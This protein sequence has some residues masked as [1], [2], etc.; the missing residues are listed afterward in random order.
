MVANELRFVVGSVVAAVAV[1]RLVEL[2]VLR[3]GSR[4]N[5]RFDRFVLVVVA[6]RI[7]DFLR[8]RQMRQLGDVDRRTMLVELRIREDVVVRIHRSWK[9]LEVHIR[10]P[11]Q[12]DRHDRTWV[13][14]S[15]IG[16]LE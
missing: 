15:C 12:R 11:K 10:C 16:K 5:L 4:L 6:R 1:E 14:G 8:R 9:V 7:L 3:F 2:A 13:L